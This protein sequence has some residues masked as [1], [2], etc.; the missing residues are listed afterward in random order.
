MIISLMGIIVFLTTN[1]AFALLDLSNQYTA[2]T[3]DTQRSVLI[4]AG[5]A[6]LS[7]GRGHAPG[8]FMGFTLLLFF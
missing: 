3:T 8:S 6:L 5:Q 2:A 4:A 7:V 1:R